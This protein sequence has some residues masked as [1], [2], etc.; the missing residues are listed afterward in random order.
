MLRSSSD[1]PVRHI[2]CDVSEREH[3]LR[4]YVASFHLT[5]IAQTVVRDLL[6]DG[7]AIDSRVEVD[8][9]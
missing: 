4:G 3:F 9:R 6:G 5:P 1:H 7:Q 8:Q 2:S